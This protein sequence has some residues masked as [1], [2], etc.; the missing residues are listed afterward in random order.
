MT[1]DIR[2]PI[3]FMFTLSG[4]IITV[5]GFVSSPEI[6][7]KSL[8]VNVNLWT[9]LAMLIFGLLFLVTGLIAQSKRRKQAPN[10]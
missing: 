9:G 8:N 10:E 3:G 7:R 5:W 1:M 4:L 6:Y 2:F